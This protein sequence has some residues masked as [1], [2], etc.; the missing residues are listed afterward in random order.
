MASYKFSRLLRLS[1]FQIGSAMGDIIV[2]S[3]WNRIMISTYH[4]PATLV[5]LLIA[6]RYLLAPISLWAGYRS[7]RTKILG[8]R[9]SPFIW[10]GR[11]LM[12][13]SLPLLVLSVERF[14]ASGGDAAGWVFA[15]ASA[16]LYGV[17]TLVSG[18]PFL[19]LVRDSV[20]PERRGFALS[21]AETSLIIWFALAGIIFS[22]IMPSYAPRTFAFL[23]AGATFFAAF[24]WGYATMGVEE[25]DWKAIAERIDARKRK[26]AARREGR[27]N[28]PP[29]NA[30]EADQGERMQGGDGPA[31]AEAGFGATYS[32][33]IRDTRT[34]QFFFFLAL[35]TFSAWI[36]DAILEPFGADVFNLSYGRTTRFN[37][38]WQGATV[39]ALLITGML[40]RRRPPE[41]QRP[42]AQWGLIAMAAGT[43]GLTLASFAGA[44]KLIDAALVLFGLGF[45]VYTFGGLSLMAV[46][47]PS[48]RAGSYLGLWSIAVLLAKGAGTL[49]G[50]ALRDT[51]IDLAGLAPGAAYGL[52]FGIEAAGLVAAALIV[53]GVDFF[54]FSRDYETTQSINKRVDKSP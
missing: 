54:G 32:L 40:L 49:V 11:G 51:L 27:G 25:P 19:A 22:F 2:T 34:R 46:M 28:S 30:G 17:G 38:Y 43:A 48:A 35:A 23:V 12:V 15:A 4:V 29:D 50:G 8:L 41:R 52:V 20:P 5:G 33:V 47:S 44:P 36:Q 14:A 42:I 21:L 6:V 7:D 31:L 1:T 18:G 39:V 16:L 26:R 10:A 53:S 3:I 37:S 13:I 24:F 45:G 9:R